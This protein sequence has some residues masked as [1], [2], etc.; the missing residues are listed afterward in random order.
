[1]EK[2]LKFYFFILETPVF[3]TEEFVIVAST[4]KEARESLKKKFVPELTRAVE[5]KVEEWIKYCKKKGFS[6]QQFETIFSILKDHLV[7]SLLDDFKLV[8]VVEIEDRG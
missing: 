8:K 1:M 7:D 5:E 4:K 3:E 2:P 6:E